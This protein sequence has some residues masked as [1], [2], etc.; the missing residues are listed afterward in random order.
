MKQILLHAIVG[1]KNVREAIAIVVRERNAQAVPFLG[2][3][4]G[5]LAHVL[6]CP[7]ASIVVKEVRR[8][9][10]IHPDGQ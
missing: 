2:G 9:P 5:T 7:V 10:G 8:A 1:D 4:P 3:D 6:E